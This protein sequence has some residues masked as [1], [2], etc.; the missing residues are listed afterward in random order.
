MPRD[1][2]GNYNLPALNPVVAGTTILDTWANNTMS[3]IAASLTNSMARDGQ[4]PATANIPFGGNKA[5]GLA[6][7]TQ[8][9]DA[10]TFNQLISSSGAS[11]DNYYLSGDGSDWT[12][13]LIRAV[14]DLGSSGTLRIGTG[15]K[16]ITS[17]PS[18][19]SV[20]LGEITFEGGGI[21][22][23]TPGSVFTFNCSIN[24][25][26]YKIFD[27]GKT[28]T[29]CDCNT[30]STTLRGWNYQFD[31]SDVGKSITF[32]YGGNYTGSSSGT[33]PTNSSANVVQDRLSYTTTVSS[34]IDSNTITLTSSPLT[35]IRQDYVIPKSFANVNTGVV[36]IGNGTINFGNNVSLLNVNWFGASVSLTDS[37]PYLQMAAYSK[38]RAFSGCEIFFPDYNYNQSSDLRIDSPGLYLKGKGGNTS[39]FRNNSIPLQQMNNITSVFRGRYGG[40]VPQP[41]VAHE[42]WTFGGSTA[43]WQGDW[44]IMS[45]LT[46]DRITVN[47]NSGNQ[48]TLTPGTGLDIWDAGVDCLYTQDFLVKSSCRFVNC[49][50]WGVA[51]ST[52]S[53]R[54]VCEDGVYFENCAEGAFY[55]EVSTG[56]KCG[57]I[58]AINSPAAG[59]NMGAVTFLRITQGEIDKP[60]ITGGNN[61]IYIRNG[62]SD[63]AI[64]V[65][66]IKG[67]A[68][69]GLWLFDESL[70]SEHL[71]NIS[72]S[73]GSISNSA[74][75]GFSFSYVDGL[76]VIGLT[77]TGNNKAGTIDHCTEFD[78]SHNPIKGINSGIIVDSGT[79]NGQAM[80]NMTDLALQGTST[81][82]MTFSVPTN[83]NYADT[84]TG[85]SQVALITRNIVGSVVGHQLNSAGLFIGSSSYISPFI[86]NTY[87]FWVDSSNRL[88]IKNGAPSSDT[89]GVVVGTQS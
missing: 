75:F 71:K 37:A 12:P 2:A 85:T 43:I 8:D 4:S 44:S 81:T 21:L 29:C 23:P 65:G 83:K 25:G 86:M 88:R 10:V 18:F 64:N 30:G 40:G 87:N 20:S 80:D 45:G 67:V 73:N 78:L 41:S 35:P 61:G 55:A 89:D 53:D 15:I 68:N 46:L 31:S 28:V 36:V 26:N 13:A 19:N 7:G 47:G 34:F 39:L 66:S 49:L 51:L 79:A 33:Y 70:G 74:S 6:N 32:T 9:G 3:D 60:V 63:I 5:T 77:G 50:R 54:G 17:S 58:H 22:Q 27:V 38:T 52:L 72:I 42:A 84:S 57:S 59:W 16:S 56:I 48:P 62:C 69:N 76:S 82:S 11:I 14:T 24:A 1:G